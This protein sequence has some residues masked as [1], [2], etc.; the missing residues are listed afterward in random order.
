MPPKRS[1]KRIGD[2]DWNN[3]I[4]QSNAL[5]NSAFTDAIKGYLNRIRDHFEKYLCPIFLPECL[6]LKPPD[7]KY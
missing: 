7:Y 1:M 2:F 6:E 5:V 4:Y 3:F